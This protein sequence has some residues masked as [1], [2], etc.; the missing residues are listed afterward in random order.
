MASA[1]II[2][3]FCASFGISVAS[4]YGQEV[5]E[6]E[7][8]ETE[9]DEIVESAFDAHL[10]HLETVK[11]STRLQ[12][13][14]DILGRNPSV[15]ISDN[16]SRLQRKTLSFRGSASQD[17]VVQYRHVALNSLSDAGADMSAIPSALF[18]AALLSNAG[19]GIAS[20]AVGGIVQLVP[21]KHET[22]LGG[23]IAVSSMKDFSLFGRGMKSFG[24][25]DVELSVFGD[26]SPGRFKYIDA[27][28][29]C[30]TREHNAAFR[31]GG[32]LAMDWK[33]QIGDISAFTL[34][35]DIEREE[36]GLSEFPSRYRYAT[37][38][39]L[40]SLSGIHGE[41]K[42][43]KAGDA[44]AQITADVS[45]RFARDIYENPTAFIGG[46]R[47]YSDFRENRLTFHAET[48]FVA[49]KYSETLIDVGYEYQNVYSEYLVSGVTVENPHDRH[50][51]EGR[52][53]ENLTFWD[54]RIAVSALL[55]I[56]WAVGADPLYSPAFAFRIRPHDDVDVWL[57]TRMG[58]RYPAFDELWYRTEYLRGNPD[59]RP[60]KSAIHEIG[61][62]YHPAEWLD[63][64]V[65][66]FYNVHRDT[67][68]FLSATPY[69]FIAENI[70]R[71][72]AWGVEI[73]AKSKF[74][75][76]FSIGAD[77]TYMH[78][79]TAEG[80]DMPTA[81]RHRVHAELGWDDDVWHA[82]IFVDWQS[83]ISRNMAGTSYLKPR[84]RPGIEAT[85]T[86]A[87]RWHL[88]VA[89]LNLLN[90]MQSED[91]LQHPLPGRQA[92]IGI[93]YE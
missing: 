79:K 62:A 82:A 18:G 27:E 72:R 33:T 34:L 20:G 44:T 14:S 31:F 74:W 12:E 38:G 26:D 92:W 86:I 19:D 85:L 11:A 42:P 84:L 25:V 67:I 83:R 81:P 73:H 61:I 59:L 78:A 89:I 63:V 76:G 32:Q 47:T 4:A 2:L 3:I 6:L 41:F 50:V 10:G 87:N 52:V 53:G 54:D 23:S 69:L 68:R 45:H 9:G 66:G 8:V 88:S 35:S 55:R 56:D 37:Q 5:L 16:G 1:R 58:A 39:Y 15:H 65:A 48:S 70:D 64:S 90:D 51:I 30:Q 29:D 17:I 49:P 43:V 57:N 60:Q 21:A 7:A 77:Y 46:R 28:G 36:A 93:S 40:L 71:V 80:Y 24:D 22:P 75:R 13:T 91:V